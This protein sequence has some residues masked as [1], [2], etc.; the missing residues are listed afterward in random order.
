MG[1]PSLAQVADA[2]D[3]LNFETA[4][5]GD[6]PPELRRTLG[7]WHVLIYLRHRRL[8]RASGTQPGQNPTRRLEGSYDIAEACFDVAGICLPIES[9]DRKV[10]YEPAASSG[11][12]PERFFRHR[13]GP[14]QTFQNR[15]QTGLSGQGPRQP[16]LFDIS[17]AQLPLDASLRPNW[18][19]E[20]RENDGNR[21][22][23]DDHIHELLVWLFRYGIPMAD[24]ATASFAANDGSGQLAVNPNI[25]S[26]PIPDDHPSL[27]ATIS[28]FFDLEDHEVD[29]LFPRLADVRIEEFSEPN[30]I[31]Y[32]DLRQELI[33]RYVPQ[34]D[35][36]E[37]ETR[38]SEID[39]T[40]FES[41]AVDGPP[42][43]GV[44]NA[45]LRS[46]AALR[47]GKFIV[48]LGPPGTGKTELAKQLCRAAERSGLVGY[49][50]ATATADWTTF[51][52]IGG[53]MPSP[54]A[55]GELT[56]VPNLV[57]DCLL[58]DRW[59]VIDELNRADIDRAFGELFT[60]FSGQEV[61]LPYKYDGRTVSL[62]PIGVEVDE[63]DVY[64]IIQS[65]AWRLI[66]TM[67]TFDKASLSQ[68]SYAFMRRFAFVEVMPP[69]RT[70]YGALLESAVNDKIRSIG[71]ETFADDVLN[72]LDRLFASDQEDTLSSIGL[73]VGPAIPLDIVRYIQKRYDALANAGD[74]V[75]AR[76]LVRE[77]LEMYLFPQF[78]GLD[79]RHEQILELL[80][81]T[82]S[83]SQPSKTAT[84]RSLSNWTGYIS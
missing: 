22:I 19:T 71:D 46:L 25:S 15:I 78:E 42:L 3:A 72:L 4:G 50:M 29:V 63:A 21:E 37:V 16:D 35:T 34:A 53:Y 52:T 20:V 73:R 57:T 14:R 10:Y 54:D 83:L 58:T 82:L 39:W 18:M 61:R 17:S 70:A 44:E 36:S 45:V 28:D 8:T 12:G 2:I 1:Y 27:R 68:L 81:T 80:T 64:P 59:L 31:G 77:G 76:L 65:T 51:E 33:S 26:D 75:N 62:A 7:L 49:V 38:V 84:S 32:C 24:G 23:L 6:D 67:N 9:G 56:F 13:E 69:N 5:S 11:S 60:L 55:A 79:E 74:E 30:P 41:N 48:L 43:V 47:A 66:G 40:A